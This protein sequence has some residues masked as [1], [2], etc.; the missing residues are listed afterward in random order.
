MYV[1]CAWQ[2][3][4]DWDPWGKGVGAPNRETDGTVKRFKFASKDYGIVT[5]EPNEDKVSG[6]LDEL[7]FLLSRSPDSTSPSLS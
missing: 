5:S 6:F 3:L 4:A 7:I 2:E 1:F